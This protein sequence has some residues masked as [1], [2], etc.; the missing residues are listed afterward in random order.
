MKSVEKNDI[1]ILFKIVIDNDV[2]VSFSI[3]TRELL[4][5]F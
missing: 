2:N 5:I 1:F 4:L 3:L